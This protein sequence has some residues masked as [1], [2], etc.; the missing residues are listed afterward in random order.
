MSNRCDPS[1]R[2]STRNSP[3]PLRC[4][5]ITAMSL[6][7]HPR[8]AHGWFLALCVCTAV[9]LP[10]GLEWLDVL[11]QSTFASGNTL[12]L[13]TNAGNGLEQSTTTLAL[14]LYVISMLS[15]AVFL[16]KFLT[17][18]RRAAQRMVQIQAWQLRQLVPQL[19]VGGS[20]RMPVA[21]T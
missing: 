19:S 5:V 13:H 3:W 1:F 18:D 17:R 15:M 14:T 2:P 7:T 12:T 11:P 10:L 8:V 20:E 6:A 21:T 16:T 4:G 9:L